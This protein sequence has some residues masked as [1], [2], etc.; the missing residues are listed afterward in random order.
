MLRALHV[1]QA[2]ILLDIPES[3]NACVCNN[4]WNFIF[5]INVNIGSLKCSQQFKLFAGYL[6]AWRNMADVGEGWDGA[7]VPLDR[8]EL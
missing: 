4:Q 1:V 2:L 6:W 8:V 3:M 7:I 5:L